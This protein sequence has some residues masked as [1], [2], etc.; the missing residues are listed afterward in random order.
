MDV[1][2]APGKG[3]PKVL[4]I[5]FEIITKNKNKKPTKNTYERNTHIENAFEK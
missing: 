5:V 2:L 3:I 4:L 1:S